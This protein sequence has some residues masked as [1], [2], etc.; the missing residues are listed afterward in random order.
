VSGLA[1]KPTIDILVRV[2]DMESENGYRG[3]IERAGWEFG[4]RDD[5]HRFFR[6]PRGTRRDVHVHVVSANHPEARR[7]L[8]FRD[9][10]RTHPEI[11]AEY[12]ADKRRRAAEFGTDVDG[13]T[14]AK[15]PFIRS[16]L[17][18]A[19]QWAAETGWQP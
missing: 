12:A 7:M 6:S 13:Y 11:A 8:L 5:D 2:E 15:T 9:Y 4:H 19:E 3:P 1:A 17:E 10:L 14:V 18:A 16:V